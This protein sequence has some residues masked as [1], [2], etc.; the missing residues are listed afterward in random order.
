MQLGER[1]SISVEPRTLPL[2]GPVPVQAVTFQRAQYAGFRTGLGARLVEVVDS[3]QPVV[4]PG[5]SVQKTGQ[6]RVQGTQVQG[7]RRRR[8]EPPGLPV[9]HDQPCSCR[10]LISSSDLQSTHWVA[11]GLASRRRRPISTPQVS[12]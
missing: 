5:A 7:A 9:S 10:S 3:H 12:Q 1:A 4:V 2:D 8:C 6:G 11:V